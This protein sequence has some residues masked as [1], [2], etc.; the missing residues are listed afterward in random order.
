[1]SNT[2]YPGRR[3]SLGGDYSFAMLF[4]GMYNL[5]TVYTVPPGLVNECEASSFY[6][7]FPGV[8]LAILLSKR[9]LRKLGILGW[10]LVAFLVGMLF[11]LFVGIPEKVAKLSLMSYVPPY[12]AD[13]A[14]GLASIILCV[15]V[16]ALVKDLNKETRSIWDKRM[17]LIAGLVLIPFFIYHGLVL[18]KVTEG[19]PG[20]SIILAVALL[21]GSLSYCL[22]AGMTAAFCGALSAILVATTAFFNPLATNLDHIYKSELAQQIIKLNKEAADR[23]LW[24]CYGGVHPGMLVTALGGRSLSGVHWP[25]QLALWRSIDPSGGGYE[26]VFNRYAQVQLAY[27]PDARWVSFDNF[28][29][30]AMEVSI[31]P[32]HPVLLAMG[33]RYVLAMG[34]AQAAVS[35][36]NLPMVYKS[37]AGSFTIFE[38]PT[39]DHPRASAQPGS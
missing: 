13:A 31:S 38:I 35:T 23:P 15:Y 3:V 29:D 4:K 12:R 18:M 2:V 17:P 6:Y 30:D 25:P 32:T 19:F 16:L 11:F 26:Q 22:L 8:F 24:I 1:M 5:R 34:E 28:Q 20:P 21:A 39:N 7:L 36:S 9:L 37:E 33:A 27:R 10:L 14:I